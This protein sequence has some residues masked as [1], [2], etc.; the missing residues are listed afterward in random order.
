MTLRLAKWQNEA[1]CD[2]N[3]DQRLHRAQVE[4]EGS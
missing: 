3:S 2:E 4:L 1:P